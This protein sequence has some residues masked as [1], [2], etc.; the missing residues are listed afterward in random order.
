MQFRRCTIPTL[1]TCLHSMLSIT[2]HLLLRK[3]AVEV[4]R[5]GLNQPI[6]EAMAVGPA[7]RRVIT[8][9]VP[10]N[11]QVTALG[12]RLGQMSI[13]RCNSTWQQGHR[14]AITTL[15]THQGHHTPTQDQ[16][17]MRRWAPQEVTLHHLS[18]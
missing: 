18:T 7:T 10:V 4:I 9:G 15:C 12:G 17:T 11:R 6:L 2:V 1:T 8:V 5:T 14:Q 13:L 3:V 16:C